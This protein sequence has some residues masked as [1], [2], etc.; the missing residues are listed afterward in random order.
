MENVALALPV[1]LLL[2][3]WEYWASK[4]KNLKYYEFN[5]SI[6]NLSIAILDR[7]TAILAAG[8]FY[9][10]YDYFQRH[11]GILAIQKSWYTWA[12]LFVLVDF[13]WYWYHRSSHEINL[14]WAVHVVHH[15]S[16]EFNLSV[17]TRITIFQTLVRMAFWIVLPLI[18][19]PAQMIMLILLVQGVYPFFVHTR[20]VGKLGWLEYV[21]VTPS[22]HRVHHASNEVYLDKNYGGV[23]IVWDRL[24]GTFALEEEEIHYGLTKPLTSRSL[25]WHLFHFFVE[26]YYATQL[27]KGFFNKIGILLGGPDKIDPTLRPA[28]EKKFLTPVQKGPL[29]FEFHR[30]IVL[31]I[32]LSIGLLLL[33]L[34]YY[35]PLPMP[36][37]VAGS[38]IVILTLINC[39]AILE[40]KSWVFHLEYL[41]FLS[42]T[43]LAAYTWQYEWVWATVLLLIAV[44]LVYFQKLR[45]TYIWSMRNGW[46]TT[47][48]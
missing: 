37:L 12:I 15:S 10:V 14:F 34:Y 30:Y 48:G 24:F 4:K 41:R 29:A 35:D 27:T 33:M 21:M 45:K 36:T 5:D 44:S 23:F 31:Q 2:I 25:L 1:L 39:G 11:F 43:V 42:I 13:L 40:Q 46:H 19:F 16:N 26:L 20:M 22:H 8:L 32:S 38:W 28:L 18:G 6:T 3:G 7:V 47:F 17:G 9:F